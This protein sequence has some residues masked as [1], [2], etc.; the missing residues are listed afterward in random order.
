M[1]ARCQSPARTRRTDRQLL[2]YRR[3]GDRGTAEEFRARRHRR[4]REAEGHTRRRL[5]RGPRRA[6]RMPAERLPAPV[7]AFAI[8]PET[9]GDEDKVVQLAAAAL[10]EEDPDESTSTATTR[11]AEQIVGR[12][13]AD[14][15]RGDRRAAANAL[16]RGGPAEAAARAL[17]GDD[18][19]AAKGDGRTRSS[20][21]AAASR[22]LPQSR[23]SPL[24]DADAQLSSL[25][26]SRAARS[27][28]RS[29][30]RS[31]KGVREAMDQGNPRRLPDQGRAG[32]AR[33][34]R[35]PHRRLVEL[36]VQARRLDRD[37]AG[38]RAGQ[39]G[40]ARADHAVTLSVPEETVGDV[41]G[42]LNARRGRPQGMERT[43]GDG[44]DQGRG[45]DG[46]LLGYAPDLRSITGG[47]G[48]YTMDFPALR[49]GPRPSRRTGARGGQGGAG[50]GLSAADGTAGPLRASP[51]LRWRREMVARQVPDEP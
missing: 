36:R 29:S 42:D 15:C 7:M 45:A 12:A 24:D 2:T 9:K 47:Q 21:A 8:E 48:D 26:R 44:R 10:Q 37:E 43:G 46:E 51:A 14:P 30:R 50:T 22:R 34:R 18:P 40:A 35:L 33:R 41:I 38:A 23:S 49:G 19:A 16:R 4:R 28:A 32:A 13:L 20:P 39:P 1:T 17:P 27:R 31:K 5:A 3:Q 6:D 25:T 11:P